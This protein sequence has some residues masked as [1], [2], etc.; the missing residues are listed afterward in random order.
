MSQKIVV[1]KLGSSLIASRDAGLYVKRI[2]SY[3]ADI[4]SNYP[5]H[6]HIFV[7]SGAREMG[8]HKARKL[9]S[10]TERALLSDKQLAGL[11]ATTVFEAFEQAHA[12]IGVA[13]S[14][15]PITHHLLAGS[16]DP[17]TLEER[18]SFINILLGNAE[19]GIASIINEADAMNDKELMRQVL[20][21]EYEIDNDQIAAYLACA[22]QATHLD[23]WKEAGGIRN[24]KHDYIAE[25]NDHNLTKVVEG[26]RGLSGGVSGRGG[27]ETAVM[28]AVIAA[29][30][31]VKT[32]ITGVNEGM[33]GINTTQVVIG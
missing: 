23:L 8:I 5:R 22:V 7:V 6:G 31:G 18:H 28:A 32:R 10:E 4:R 16:A 30:A 24:K 27:P 25:I 3:V 14:S 20:A 21:S 26:L 29:R 11:G 19:R 15:Y 1:S 17:G 13:A 9:F 33:T 12:V 2:N